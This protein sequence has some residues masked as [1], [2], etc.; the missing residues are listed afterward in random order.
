MW[1]FN[2]ERIY[3]KIRDRQR[4]IARGRAQDING[5]H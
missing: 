2:K 5:K 4:E 1:C 3:N